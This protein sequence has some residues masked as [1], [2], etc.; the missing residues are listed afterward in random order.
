[1]ASRSAHKYTCWSRTV[2]PRHSGCR[3]VVVG[4]IAFVSAGS[5]DSRF[6]VKWHPALPTRS[7]TQ[8]RPP[9]PPPTTNQPT[10]THTHTVEGLS[11]E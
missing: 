1:M 3:V 5:T 6:G 9:D 4:S 10:P 7:H 11:I 8:L 2:T